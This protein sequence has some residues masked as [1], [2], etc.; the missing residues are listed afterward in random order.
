MKVALY[1]TCAALLLAFAAAGCQKKE[2][3][4]AAAPAAAEIAQKIC[5]V[6]GNPINK[7]IYVDY[8]GRRVYFCC[9]MCPPVFN[10]DPEKYIKILDEQLK[11]AKPGTS[12]AAGHEGHT[13]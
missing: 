1:V 9:P 13:D 2:Q 3:P 4:Y 11:G 5:P 12:A 8:K 10:R 6:M 7:D